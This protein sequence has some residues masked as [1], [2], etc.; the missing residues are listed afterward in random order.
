[1][2]NNYLLLDNTSLLLE[3][4][5][6]DVRCF[7]LFNLNVLLPLMH[8]MINLI[9]EIYIF[10][11]FKEHPLQNVKVSWKLNYTVDSSLP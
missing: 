10:K 7:S 11:K 1:M 4:A 8:I 5:T 9:K 6:S 2:H 3:L